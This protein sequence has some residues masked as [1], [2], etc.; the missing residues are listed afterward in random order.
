MRSRALAFSH[1]A[2]EMELDMLDVA[3]PFRHSGLAGRMPMC[4]DGQSRSFFSAARMQPLLR[5]ADEIAQRG[6]DLHI[7][8]RQTRH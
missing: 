5:R 1:V 8:D 4:D 6:L 3:M 2:M 7:A